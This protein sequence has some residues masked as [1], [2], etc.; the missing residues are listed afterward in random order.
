MVE[1]KQL[2]EAKW[3]PP[4]PTPKAT[5]LKNGQSWG[6]NSMLLNSTFFSPQEETKFETLLWDHVQD[7]A[8]VVLDTDFLIDIPWGF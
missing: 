1:E 8:C 4:H 3:S 7:I 6:L 2:K 5:Q